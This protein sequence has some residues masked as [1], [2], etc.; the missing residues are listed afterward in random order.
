IVGEIEDQIRKYLLVK[1]VISA[2]T[3]I[4]F[5]FALWLFGI[6]LAIV[7]GFLAF[8]LNF[9]PN[10]GPL[11]SSCLPVPF[12][13]LNSEMSPVTAISCFLTISSIQFVSG[14]VIETRIMGKS[15]DVSPI[16]LLLALMFF[17][18]V[19]GILG[20]FLATPIVS[21]IKIIFQKH[22]STRPFAELMAGRLSVVNSIAAENQN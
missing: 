14:N 10:I 11:I 3:G 20:M 19:W 21:I 9:I 16:V 13:V 22:E 1:T 8:L 7:F 6:P 4:A 15:F 5:G 12:L 18:L 2:L 17:G